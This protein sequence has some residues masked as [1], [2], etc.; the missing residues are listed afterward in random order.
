MF[1][2]KEWIYDHDEPKARYSLGQE[3]SNPFV[4][5]GVNPSTAV[6]GNLDPTVASVARF[7]T[8]HSYDG[9]LMFNLYPQRAT[10]PNNM[11]RK[12]QSSIHLKN[13]DAIERLL[14]EVKGSIDV[15]C[16]WGTLIEKRPYL[17]RCLTEIYEVLSASNC[18]YLSRGSISKAGHP[19]H[20]LYLKK[21]APL[22]VFDL[23][24]YLSERP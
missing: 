21:T 9:W 3:G 1:P 14:N 6:P 11:H 4:C 17:L 2:D 24:R 8:N 22:E 10:N 13:L 20:P 23:N 7:A 15:W 19:H 5:F 12:F 18:R 16:A